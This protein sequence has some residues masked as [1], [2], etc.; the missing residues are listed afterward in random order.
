MYHNKRL[1]SATGGRRC[2][3]VSPA[4]EEGEAALVTMVPG[5]ES[6]EGLMGQQDE[7]YRHTQ[8][9]WVLLAAL[10]AGAGIVVFAA[11]KTGW[12]AAASA[13]LTLL[14]VVALLFCTLTVRIRGG[15]IECRFGPG[16]IS[17]HIPLG[18]GPGG[19]P[20][21][22]RVVPGVG[23]P[24]HLGRLALQRLGPGR[25]RSRTGRR[26]DGSGSAPT[27]RRRWRPRSGAAPSFPQR[28]DPRIIAP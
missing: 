26:E 9:G 17:K 2:P 8:I 7:T 3:Q 22:D 16:L 28:P 14:I 1:Q 12:S 11:G 25:R 19:P 5:A 21:P 24:P 6:M 15:E 10:A 27:S 20:G 18:G 13:V 23:D 4:V